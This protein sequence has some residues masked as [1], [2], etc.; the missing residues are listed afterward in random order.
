MIVSTLWNSMTTNGDDILP[1]SIPITGPRTLLSAS[2]YL[3]NDELK[4]LQKVAVRVAE[5]VARLARGIY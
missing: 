2:L 5:D 3:V 4:G 1:K